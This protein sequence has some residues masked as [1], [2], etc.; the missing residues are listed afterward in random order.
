MCDVLI[1]FGKISNAVL[2]NLAKEG[3]ITIIC[4]QKNYNNNYKQ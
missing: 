2:I 3:N 1:M 4:L